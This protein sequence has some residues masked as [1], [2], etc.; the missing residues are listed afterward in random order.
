MSAKL[1]VPKPVNEPVK[2]YL[3][4]SPERAELK[5]KLEELAGQV[6][7]IPL[8]IGG[9]EIR[10]GDT[11]DLVMPHDHSHVLG[12]YHKAGPEEI[13]KAIQASQEAHKEWAAW[14]WEDRVAVMLK[15]GELLSTSWRSTINAATMLGQSKTAHQ[16]EIDSAAELVDFFRFNAHFAQELYEEQPISSKGIWNSVEYRPLEGFIYAITPFNF[17]SIAGNLPSAPALMGNTV[18]WKPARTSLLSSF[19][20]Q[21]LFEEA[22][23]PP[24]VINFI[25]GNSAEITRQVFTNPYFAGVHFTGSTPV[26][27]SMWNA[28]GENIGSYKGYPRLVGETGGKDFIIAHPSADPEAVVTAIVRGAFEYQGQ[29]CSAASR[30][31]LAETLWSEIKDTLVSQTEGIAMG[32]VR[33]FRNF[34]GAVIDRAAYDKITGYIE[35][36]RESADS[37]IVAGGTFDD[38]KGY[39]IRPTIVL[40]K[41]P[42]VECMCDEIFGPVV[43]VYVYPDAEWSETLE[44]VD[45]TGDYALTGAVF[46]K[47]R[48]AILE[49][50][51]ALRFAA[52]NY[53]INDK[54]TGAVVGQQPFGGARASGTND[55]AGSKM[56][57][58]RWVSAR[59]MKETFVPP[60]SYGYPFMDAE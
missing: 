1:Q 24:G 30:I 60:T 12:T 48:G 52:G 5:A 43:T 15:A 9:E 10:T 57:L 51:K 56:N 16:A 53:Y 45:Q 32:D 20:I 44:L 19:F 38:S 41:K 13:K 47:D 58:L 29:K 6:T 11:A 46:S 2:D 28:V 3:P 55:K 18:L 49:A 27:N 33:D 35:R 25:T 14:P 50:N 39:F 31:Y 21:K 37:E 54:P 26:F 8:V 40:A 34:M 17:T 36:A 4:G 23:L 42:D 59:T 22:G 7:D